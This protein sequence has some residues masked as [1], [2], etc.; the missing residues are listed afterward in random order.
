MKGHVQVYRNLHANLPSGKP[1]FSVRNDKGLVEDHVASISL[2]DPVFRVSKAGNERVR[3]EK[4][5]NVHAYIQGK[6]MKGEGSSGSYEASKQRSNSEWHKVTYNP[7][8]HEHFV[9]AEDESMRV[10]DAFIMEIDSKGVWAFKPT[11][12]KI[13]Q[14]EV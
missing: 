8:K 14:L 2:L 13:N 12:K 5:K 4:R 6:R 9:L 1:V 3:K 11:L 7:Y 10:E